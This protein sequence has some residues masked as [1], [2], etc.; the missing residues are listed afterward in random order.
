MIR[1]VSM[2]VEFKMIQTVGF[3]LFCFNDGRFSVSVLFLYE[4]SMMVSFVWLWDLQDVG[5]F[6][7]VPG[8][9]RLSPLRVGLGPGVSVYVSAM[10]QV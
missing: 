10:T 8:D 5:Q 3:V 7:S 9:P 1:F 6:F 4:I 2:T